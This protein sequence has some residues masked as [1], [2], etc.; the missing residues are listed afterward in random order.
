[1]S[2][3]FVFLG[4]ATDEPFVEQCDCGEEVISKLYHQ[5]D[6]VEVSLAAEAAGD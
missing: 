3:H 5:F 1:M 6:I 2:F 4:L